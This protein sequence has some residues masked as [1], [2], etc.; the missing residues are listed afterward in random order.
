MHPG[1]IQPH[2]PQSQQYH[3]HQHDQHIPSNYATS[4]NMMMMQGG[5]PVPPPSESWC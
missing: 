5:T 4:P 2:H 1:Q 3:P